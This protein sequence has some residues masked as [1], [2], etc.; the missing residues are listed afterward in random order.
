MPDVD[1]DGKSWKKLET[2]ACSVFSEGQLFLAYYLMRRCWAG[3]LVEKMDLASKT[4]RC[5]HLM[6]GETPSNI[7]PQP[8]RCR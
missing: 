4:H 7:Q 5:I 3:S 6:F 2:G 8:T 1:I